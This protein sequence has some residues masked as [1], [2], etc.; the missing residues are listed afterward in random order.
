MSR[1][2]NPNHLF[3]G[4]LLIAT[5]LLALWLARKLSIGTTSSM[6][7]GYLPRLLCFIQIGLG[8]A[9]AVRGLA[10]KG[11][12]FEAWFPRPLFWTLASIAFF[13]LTVERLGI[14]VAITGLVI[15]S[16]LG[17]R[18]TKLFGEAVPLAI[19]MTVFSILVFVVGLKLPMSVM[20][21]LLVP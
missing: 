2:R 9:I 4:I 1:I 6:G 13:G 20:P 10:V 5:A 21:K 3:T 17:N 11:D 16:A 15:L 14:A 12:P 7:P 18:A 8:F 19:A